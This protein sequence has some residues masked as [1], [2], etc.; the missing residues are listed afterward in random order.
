MRPRRFLL[1]GLVLACAVG[2][3][4]ETLLTNVRIA[5][6]TDPPN[7][8]VYALR[9]GQSVPLQ[10]VDGQTLV[11]EVRGP[12]QLQFGVAGREFKTAPKSIPREACQSGEWPTGSERPFR[13]ALPPEERA[14]YDQKANWDKLKIGL[15]FV[16]VGGAGLLTFG[17]LRRR[18][19]KAEPGTVVA[20]QVPQRIGNYEIVRLLATGG[21]SDVYIARSLTALNPEEEFALKLLRGNVE[22]QEQLARERKRFS[23]EAQVCKTVNHRNIVQFFDW[24]EADGHFYLVHELLKGKTLREVIRDRWTT[25]PLFSNLEVRDLANQVGAALAVVHQHQLVHRDLKPDNLFLTDDGC[26]K[27]MDFGITRGE[28]LTVA[29]QAGAVMGTVIYMAPEQIRGEINPATDQYSLGILLFELLTG[30]RPFEDP[31]AAKVMFA[32]VNE[33]PPPVTSKRPD[34]SRE[35]DLVLMKMLNKRPEQRYENVTRAVQ[36]FNR[37]LGFGSS[38]EYAEEQGTVETI[39]SAD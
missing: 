11:G 16:A 35:L 38:Q 34:L 32:H 4:G 5:L 22:S 10:T 37:A 25:R 6:Y 28:N 36:E 29:T 17:W 27:L 20:T 33:A 2:V 7:L 18:Q 24:G 26:L 30:N 19:L 12:L 15:P 8:Q 23:R 1:A 9:D 39:I 3:N 13:V 14:V 21:M 31:D